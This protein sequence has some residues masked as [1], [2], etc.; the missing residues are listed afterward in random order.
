[1]QTNE[2]KVPPK[3]RHMPRS[4]ILSIEVAEK[5]Q[6]RCANCR[7][8]IVVVRTEI[9]DC[10]HWGLYPDSKKANLHHRDRNKKNNDI[11][12]LEILCIPCHHLRHRHYEN[13]QLSL[14][15]ALKAKR[16]V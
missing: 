11:S 2:W 3:P 6:W 9:L 16:R 5:Q 4:T 15:N 13:P 1:M 8:P 14:D 10:W 7:E 12:N